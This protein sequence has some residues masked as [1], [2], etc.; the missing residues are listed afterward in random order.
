[1]TQQQIFEG[2]DAPVDN[3]AKLQ[4]KFI[5]PPFS[6]LDT[7]Q[8]YW[9]ERKRLWLSLGIQSELGRGEG[10][11]FGISVDGLDTHRDGVAFTERGKA[12]ARAFAQDVMRGEHTVRDSRKAADKRSNVTGA[13]A[14]PDWATGTGTT[15]M[16]PGTSI[17]DPVLCELAYKWFCPEGGVIFDPFAGGSVRGIVASLLGYKYYGIDLSGE[18]IKAN[19]E[20]GKT[21]TPTNPPVWYTGDSNNQKEILPPELKAD[22]VFSCPPYHDL[23]Q[24][25]DDMDDLSNMSWDS[26]K[27][28]YTGIIAKSILRLKENRFACFVVGEIR[29]DIGGYKGL[30]PLTVNAFNAGGM[31]YYNELILVNVAGSLPIRIDG[32]FS[33]SRKIGKMHQNVLVFYKGDIASI[34]KHFK[35]VDSNMPELGG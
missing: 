5:V 24:Y 6:V 25:T 19:I 23:E 15:N 21:L 31:R 8:G 20:Q 4:Q 3:R 2:F 30:V 17:F 29:D 18:Q 12:K 35:E 13:P 14:K 10:I 33:A 16:A 28:I 34:P 22:F 7:R 11:T 9:Q 26:F 32:Q 1:L 27:R